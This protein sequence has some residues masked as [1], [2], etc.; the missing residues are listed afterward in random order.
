MTAVKDAQRLL[1]TLQLSEYLVVPVKT[2]RSWREHR[3]GPPY[4]KVNGRLVRYR[5]S[6]VEAWLDKQS[7]GA[8]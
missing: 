5:V 4:I 7:V 2:I 3:Q 8:A 1:T 6:A